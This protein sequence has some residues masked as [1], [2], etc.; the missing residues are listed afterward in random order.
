MVTVPISEK[1]MEVVEGVDLDNRTTNLEFAYSDITDSTN[2]VLEAIV[3]LRKAIQFL[4]DGH[5]LLTQVRAQ[6]A[7]NPTLLVEPCDGKRDDKALDNFFWDMEEMFS[8][9]LGL[10]DE[11]QLKKAVALLTGGAK[12]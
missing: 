2:D 10:S 8:N 5:A 3:K 11:A 1:R 9:M 6:G 7:L 12:L 4:K